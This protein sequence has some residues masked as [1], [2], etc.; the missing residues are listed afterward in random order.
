MTGWELL[1]ALSASFHMKRHFM[2]MM[3]G[4][5]VLRNEDPI[6]AQNG[7]T[8]HVRDRLM[9]GGLD[10]LGRT[11]VSESEPRQ[12]ERDIS[13]LLEGHSVDGSWSDP[14]AML[15]NAGINRIP[16]IPRLESPM[17]P[18]VL[19]TILALAIF[20]KHHSD[21]YEFW[22]L[23][24]WKALQW[25]DRTQPGRRWSEIVDSLVALLP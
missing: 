24:E 13:T 8:I 21:E 23:L 19:A 9:G 3:C 12:R 4:T 6:A 16:R 11:L 14:S 2:R 25:L 10:E 18:R 20:R 1:T 5:R 17:P 15:A 7:D 22:K